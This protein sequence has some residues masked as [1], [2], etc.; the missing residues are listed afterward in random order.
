MSELAKLKPR[1]RIY[2]TARAR[3]L[4]KRQAALAAGAKGEMA[5]DKYG[6]RMS[7]NV[8][9]QRAI[10][11]ALVKQGADPEFAVTKIVNVASMELTHQAAPSILKAS[12]T[13]L[14]LHG[15]RKEEKPNMTLNIN[16]FF[17]KARST[18]KVDSSVDVSE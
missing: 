15:W 11:E 5:A 3:G 9:V 13:I 4:P 2:A 17:G 8:Q 6:T 10:D 12:N 18:K 1:E 16:Q 7:G 14:E